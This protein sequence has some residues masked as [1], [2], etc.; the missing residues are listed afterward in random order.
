MAGTMTRER[1]TEQAGPGVEEAK[2]EEPEERVEKT[3]M[4]IPSSVFLFAAGASILASL[5]L[6]MRKNKEASL[7]VGL[8]APTILGLAAFWKLMQPS[9]ED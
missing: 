7:F 5:T 9:K 3:M 1:M 8:W 6:F 2:P 4:E